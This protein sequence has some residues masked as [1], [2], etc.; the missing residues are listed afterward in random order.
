LCGERF[1]ELL[2]SEQP[3]LYRIEIQTPLS[4]DVSLLLVYLTTPFNFI[5]Y[6]ERNGQMVLTDEV[7]IMWRDAFMAYFQLLRRHFLREMRKN[8]EEYHSG[9]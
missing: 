9:H 5:N 4:L 7:E 2:A 6:S 8:H 1:S 3:V